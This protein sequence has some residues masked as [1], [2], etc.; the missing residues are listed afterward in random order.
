MSHRLCQAMCENV[1]Q[2]SASSTL[3]NRADPYVDVMLCYISRFE[4][5]WCPSPVLSLLH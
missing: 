3:T 2:Q 1:L 4:V 5:E